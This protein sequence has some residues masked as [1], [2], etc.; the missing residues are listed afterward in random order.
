MTATIIDFNAISKISKTL[1][2]IMSVLKELKSQLPN[3]GK[4]ITNLNTGE[5]GFLSVKKDPLTD[6]LVK[7]TKAALEQLSLQLAEETK[8]HEETFANEIQ[9][10]KELIERLSHSC[11]QYQS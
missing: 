1:D 8:G 4:T 5:Q 9:S 2:E 10:I 6:F 7:N 3:V 11:R